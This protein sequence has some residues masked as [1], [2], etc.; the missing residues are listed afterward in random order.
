MPAH[1]SDPLAE[2]TRV[3]PAQPV[4]DAAP[5]A[6][7]ADGDDATEA[8]VPAEPVLHPSAAPEPNEAP[9]D[10]DPTAAHTQQEY[11]GQ[12]A[13]EPP[14]YAEPSG[15]FDQSSPY[16]GQHLAYGHPVE[17]PYGG[18]QYEYS[19]APAAVGYPT[20]APA[21]AQPRSSRGGVPGKPV[22]A[23]G[24]AFLVVAL[25]APA[26]IMAWRTA[27]GAGVHP[28]GV[29]GGLLAVTGLAV[30]AT[31]LFSL[32]TGGLATAEGDAARG[33]AA[34]LTRPP[35]LLVVVGAVLLVT[36]GIAEGI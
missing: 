23:A 36:A 30:L 26:L 29:I 1:S 28:A 13:Y 16:S 4:T 6:S 11:P 7:S 15:V 3:L 14:S 8:A 12:P 2:A 25:S 35:G 18:G 20:E 9:V 10:N 19:D 31:G 33:G 32:L 24:L 21:G 27:V 17:T 22:V 34:E 5:A